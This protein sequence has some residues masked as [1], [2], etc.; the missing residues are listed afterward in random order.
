MNHIY[1]E[2]G[3]TKRTG[4]TNSVLI[5]TILTRNHYQR[6]SQGEG[7]GVQPPPLNERENNI[8]TWRTHVLRH[9]TFWANFDPLP[10]R[11]SWLRP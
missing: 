10:M 3:F 1:F 8:D 7:L 5:S 4:A 9:T 11:N 2:T 6:R